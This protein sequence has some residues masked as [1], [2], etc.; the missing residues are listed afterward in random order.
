[1]KKLAILL[2]IGILGL[3][4]CR[5]IFTGHNYTADEVIQVAKFLNISRTRVQKYMRGDITLEDLNVSKDRLKQALD[6]VKHFRD[7]NSTVR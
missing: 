7:K 6:Y 3:A 1:M 4:G 5:G 2:F